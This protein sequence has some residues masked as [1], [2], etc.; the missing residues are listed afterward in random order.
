MKPKLQMTVGAVACGL[1]LG[2][3]T[4]AWSQD[5]RWYFRGGVGGTWMPDTEL[6]EFFG[7]VA[8]GTKVS[9][10]PGINVTAVGGYEVT[11]WFAAE[12]ETGIMANRISSITGADRLDDAALSNIPLLLNARFQWPGSC[13]LKPYLGGGLGGSAAILEADHMDIGGTDLH[14]TQGAAVFAYDAFGGV[15]CRLNDHM[16]ISVE[17]RYFA[18]TDPD[19][20]A[21][22]TVGTATDHLNM[23]GV[24]NHSVSLVFDMKF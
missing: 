7:P 10:D 15:R 22:S 9:F 20:H 6:K 14:G 24:E 11:D 5:T 13:L 3:S 23:G 17:Y 12:G 8:P 18:T 1:L 2:S 4:V 21:E 16:G 19:W